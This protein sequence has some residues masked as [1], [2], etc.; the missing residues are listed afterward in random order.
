MPGTWKLG[1]EVPQETVPGRKQEQP[2]QAVHGEVQAER[3]HPRP[4]LR[5]NRHT[6]VARE[7][8]VSAEG[9]RNWIRQDQTDRGQ[10]APGELTTAEREE[11]RRQRRQNRQQANTYAGC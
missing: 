11:L 9:L 1:R 3:G 8:G 7:L 10:D 4:L 2:Q 5:Q 6:E